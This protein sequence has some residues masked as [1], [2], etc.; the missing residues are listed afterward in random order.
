MVCKRAFGS[1]WV[2]EEL[3]RLQSGPGTAW[4]PQV[5][6]G[7]GWGSSVL[8]ENAGLPPAWLPFEG[9]PVVWMGVVL[10]GQGIG[11]V[12]LGGDSLGAPAYSAKWFLGHGFLQ[13]LRDMDLVL[14]AEDY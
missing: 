7:G 11:G 3:G 8:N 1:L 6:D 14:L 9:A 10:V 13:G 12:S 5:N 2:R 4:E